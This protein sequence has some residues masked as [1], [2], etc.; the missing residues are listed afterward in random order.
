MADSFHDDTARSRFELDVDG[1]TAFARYRRQDERLVIE[2][3]EAEP[4]LRGTGAAGRL[5]ERIVAVAAAENR[6]IV[7]LCGYAASWLRRHER[8]A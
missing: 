3:V 2:H 8:R 7:P 4:A 5:M 6:S 1:R